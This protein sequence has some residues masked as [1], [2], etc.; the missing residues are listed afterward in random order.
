MVAGGHYSQQTHQ[1]VVL[2]YLLAVSQENLPK[3]RKQKRRRVSWGKEWKG[4]GRM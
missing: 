4:E 3:K 1:E 2:E